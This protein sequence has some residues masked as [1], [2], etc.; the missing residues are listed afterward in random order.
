MSSSASRSGAGSLPIL[1]DQAL[2]RITTSGFRVSTKA[3]TRGHT[4]CGAPGSSLPPA[5]LRMF[6]VKPFSRASDA[7]SMPYIE[8]WLSP[9]RTTVPRLPPATSVPPDAS[10]DGA[11][12][13]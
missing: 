5:R 2:A 13:K 12:S 1:Y 6:S 9:A 11:A 7:S 8:A 10:F 4:V 3:R